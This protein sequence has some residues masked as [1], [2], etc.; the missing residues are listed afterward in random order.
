M[1][2]FVLAIVLGFGAAGFGT[3]CRS[4][5]NCH[6]YDPPVADCQ[7]AGCTACGHGRAGSVLSGGY[8]G[9]ELITE[10]SVYDS[11]PMHGEPIAPE[12]VE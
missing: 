9:G 4:C 11:Q 3:G 6:D 10:P 2:R 7:C 5:Q 8:M 1:K 12:V